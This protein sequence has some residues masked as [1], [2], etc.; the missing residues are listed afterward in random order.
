MDDMHFYQAVNWPAPSAADSDLLLDKAG[1][2]F[3]WVVDKRAAGDSLEMQEQQQQQEL[4]HRP[5]QV[6]IWILFQLCL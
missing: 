2:L 6:K 1:P 3:S 5:V 4:L